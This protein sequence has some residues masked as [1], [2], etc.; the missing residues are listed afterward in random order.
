MSLK[1]K[2]FK[3]E[4]HLRSLFGKLGFI[5]STLEKVLHDSAK[6]IVTCIQ[7]PCSSLLLEF[8]NNDSQM[9]Q[10]EKMFATITAIANSTHIHI[11]DLS[12]QVL[13]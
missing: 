2:D 11:A 7:D 1:A 12:T 10:F 8:G 4:D 5:F 3:Y 6:Q 9:Q 13:F